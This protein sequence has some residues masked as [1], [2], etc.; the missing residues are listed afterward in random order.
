MAEAAVEPLPSR[1]GVVCAPARPGY[2]SVAYARLLDTTF[3]SAIDWAYPSAGQTPVRV[4]PQ[5]DAAVVATLGPHFVQ[6]L[7]FE[8]ADSEPA[9]G[10]SQWAHVAT[11]DGRTGFVA[12]ASL[13]SLTTEQLCYMKDQIA[14]W[15]IAG[16]ITGAIGEGHNA[17]AN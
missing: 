12:P 15:R 16:Y 13:M 7:G 5:R 3:T 10:R 6:L 9:P 17:D 14:G 11:P 2:D 4:A 1:S 8:G